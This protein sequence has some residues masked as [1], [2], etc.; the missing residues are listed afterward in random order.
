[1]QYFLKAVVAC[2]LAGPESPV[3][4]RNLVAVNI[5]NENCPAFTLNQ[6]FRPRNL[7]SSRY[8]YTLS[9]NYP[10]GFWPLDA[11]SRER[12][13]LFVFHNQVTIPVLVH[14]SS[15]SAW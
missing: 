7:T 10:C 6:I 3:D 15:E 11:G 2:D 13:L 8:E 14:V 12:P 1:M 9:S 4:E 5:G